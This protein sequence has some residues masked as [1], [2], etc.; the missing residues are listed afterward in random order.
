[1]EEERCTREDL[2]AHVPSYD[3]WAVDADGRPKYLAFEGDTYLDNVEEYHCDVCDK[4]FDTWEEALA[5]LV[6][7]VSEAA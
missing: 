7:Q 3:L 4:F 2:H 5:H 1:M 6:E